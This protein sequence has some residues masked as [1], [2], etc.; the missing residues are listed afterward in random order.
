MNV[1][2]INTNSRLINLGLIGLG[3]FLG[4]FFIFVIGETYFRLSIKTEAS[5]LSGDFKM[6]NESRGWALRP[7]NYRH[8]NFRAFREVEFTVN[9]DGLRNH[10]FSFALPADKERLTILGDSFVFGEAL[11]DGEHL[12]DQLQKLGEEQFEFINVSTPGY[13]TGQ[14]ILLIKDLVDHGY[15]I[16]N[17][18]ILAFFTNDILD[19]LGLDYSL[20]RST[21]KPV[22]TI[23]NRGE[24]DH[25]VPEKPEIRKTRRSF[26]ERSLFFNFVRS[27]IEILIAAN[28][29]LL[30]YLEIFGIAPDLPRVPGIITG[31]YNPGWEERW[32]VTR[33]LLIYLAK[34]TRNEYGADLSILF[35]PSP[36]QASGIHKAILANKREKDPRYETFL[37]DLERPQNLLR[38]FCDE[39]GIPFIDASPALQE[40]GKEIPMFFPREGHLNEHGSQVVA[41]LLYRS[42]KQKP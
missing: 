10:K 36:F 17:K 2:A 8:F 4:I 31:W 29:E 40:T 3:T 14:E 6:Y 9:E 30:D 18:L 16:G 22:F 26:L 25:S 33:D 23:N 28:S 13:G 32:A 35:I 11:N 15:Q 34:L 21:I 20:K 38:K 27:R 39:L 37:E 42:I 5:G 24:I 7:G 19:N 12:T 41:E 1:T